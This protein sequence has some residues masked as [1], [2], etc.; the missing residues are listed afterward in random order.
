MFYFVF[1]GHDN[2]NRVNHLLFCCC[3]QGTAPDEAYMM[4]AFGGP[5]WFFWV[6]MN[7]LYVPFNLNPLLQNILTFQLCIRWWKE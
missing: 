5:G 4:S 7:P 2:G 6:I 1:W 3:S